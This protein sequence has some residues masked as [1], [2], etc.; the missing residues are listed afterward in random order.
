MERPSWSIVQFAAVLGGG[1][2][3]G[4]GAVATPGRRAHDGDRAA[5]QSPVGSR[6]APDAVGVRARVDDEGGTWC[7][8]RGARAPSPMR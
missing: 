4:L 1:F 6:L 2:L 3:V 8:M 5:R 7:R